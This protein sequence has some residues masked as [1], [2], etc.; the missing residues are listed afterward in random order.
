VATINSGGLATAQGVGSTTIT[1]TVA[2]PMTCTTTLTVT[3]VP[4]LV[5][6][7]VVPPNQTI[8]VGASKQYTAIGIYSNGT[9]QN[10]SNQVTWS[11]SDIAVATIA[12]HGLA[13][14]T[15]AGTTVITATLGAISGST[16]LTVKTPTIAP[17]PQCP[18]GPVSYLMEFNFAGGA[19]TTPVFNYNGPGTTMSGMLLGSV[20]ASAEVFN[21]FAAGDNGYGGAIG[22]ITE[23]NQT[24]LSIF[25]FGM[26]RQRFAWWEIR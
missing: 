25:Q 2:G 3:V 22:F 4:S 1:A 18:N 12:V 16:N 14:G 5:S 17:P 9:T 24:I 11:S 6:I 21:N 15:L 13:T 8:L 20:Y 7:Q 26:G 10:L 19:F 23:S